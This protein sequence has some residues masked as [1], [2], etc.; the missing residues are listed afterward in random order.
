MS[1]RFT[2][3]NRSGSKLWADAIITRLTGS[4]LKLCF[5][6]A[7]SSYL[8]NTDIT[9]FRTPNGVAHQDCAYIQASE[10]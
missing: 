1:E 9:I 8:N 4:F 5:N 6:Y 10:I 7:P 2:F 3:F